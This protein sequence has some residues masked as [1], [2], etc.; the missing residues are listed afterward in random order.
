MALCTLTD[1]REYLGI[2]GVDATA[3][4]V[5]TRL[6]DVVTTLFDTYCNRTLLETEHTEYYSCYGTNYIVLRNYPVTLI[7]SVSDDTNYVWDV[8]TI[9]DSDYYFLDNTI[10]RLKNLYF[11]NYPQSVQVIYTA[12]YT[13]ETLPEDLKQAAILEVA[14][15]YKK[16][17]EGVSVVSRSTG[18]SSITYNITN[19]QPTTKLVLDLYRSVLC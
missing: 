14:H 5:M 15:L 8:D 10:L 6:C 2:T 11:A 17:S 1:V 13:T 4:S 19:L 3:N 18:E 16:S 9:I 12:G 7:T